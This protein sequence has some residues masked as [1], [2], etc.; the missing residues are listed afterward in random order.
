MER[1]PSFSNARTKQDFVR[2][3]VETGTL[4][5][6]RIRSYPY[7]IGF[8]Y[9]DQLSNEK[10]QVKRRTEVQLHSWISG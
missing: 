9:P 6:H 2:D 10:D 5:K 7:T 1:D 4:S 8:D 3:E